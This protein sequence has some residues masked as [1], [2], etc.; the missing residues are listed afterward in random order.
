[1]ISHRYLRLVTF[2]RFGEGVAT[3]VWFVAIGDALFVETHA[4]SGKAKRIRR[5]PRVAFGPCT[6]RGRLRGPMARGTA[7]EITGRELEVR[8]AM[9]QRYGLQMRFRQWWLRRK[10]ITPTVLEIRADAP[11]GTSAE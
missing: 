10:G 5:D 11:V 4:Q 8:A 9:L 6:A 3:P 2:R 7:R 1:M